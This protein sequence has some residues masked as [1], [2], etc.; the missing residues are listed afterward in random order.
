M[1]VLGDQLDPGFQHVL[2]HREA[3]RTP[4]LQLK[5]P[6]ANHNLRRNRT[7]PVAEFQMV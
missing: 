3:Q 1:V 2:Y 6:R 5:A 4:R 7:M